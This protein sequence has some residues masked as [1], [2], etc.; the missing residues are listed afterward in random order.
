[1]YA[2]LNSQLQGIVK[3]QTETLEISQRGLLGD[4]GHAVRRI[5]HMELQVD[6]PGETYPEN[7]GDIITAEES[8]TLEEL[9]TNQLKIDVSALAAK[10][11]VGKWR[12]SIY[13]LF[14][15]KKW[16]IITQ[17]KPQIAYSKNFFFS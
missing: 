15:A 9:E 11:G 7:P 1:M 6:D 16:E 12:L 13:H 4:D 17:N 8:A 3:S 2:F 14:L 5:E 10:A